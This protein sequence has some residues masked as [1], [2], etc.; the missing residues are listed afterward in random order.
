MELMSTYS[1]CIDLACPLGVNYIVYPSF[2]LW[3]LEDVPRHER[4]VFWCRLHV[5]ITLYT[6]QIG[7]DNCT[8]KVVITDIDILYIISRVYNKRKR[9]L[10]LQYSLCKMY[11][12]SNV[13]S[14]Y[15]HVIKR[16]GPYNSRCISRAQLEAVFELLLKD[17]AQRRVHSSLSWRFRSQKHSFRQ[18]SKTTPSIIAFERSVFIGQIWNSKRV[19]FRI[20]D[21]G[22]I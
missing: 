10:N 5:H 9:A 11:A 13:T 12:E 15:A 22:P 17:S 2:F 21:N 7:I 4:A 1:V 18:R 20:H 14:S 16:F 3:S 19:T 6:I 8:P